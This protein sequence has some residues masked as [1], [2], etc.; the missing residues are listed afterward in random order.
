MVSSQLCVREIYRT[1]DGSP[2]GRIQIYKQVNKRPAGDA[3]TNVLY[4]RI[5]DGTRTEAIVSFVSAC[6]KYN[7]PIDFN[8]TL[9]ERGI[10]REFTYSYLAS[11]TNDAHH[12]TM[13][14]LMNRYW[15]ENPPQY[16]DP[17]RLKAIT[18]GVPA[19]VFGPPQ[20]TDIQ[21]LQCVVCFEN[22]KDCMT[23][24]NHLCMCSTCALA[25]TACP[26]CRAVIKERKYV[27]IS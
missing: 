12:R 11:L 23:Q 17:E 25:V 4:C 22:Q 5:F 15:I 14:A 16:I 8:F 26:M 9:Q 7:I 3:V 6:R 18:K 27:I 19:R 20:T 21:A 2:L 24:C 1:H 10:R 13:L